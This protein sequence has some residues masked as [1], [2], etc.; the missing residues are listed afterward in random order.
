MCSHRADLWDAACQ[1]E[2]II[3]SGKE[4][5]Q[6]SYIFGPQNILK[7]FIFALC[8]CIFTCMLYVNV[9]HAY[10][11]LMKIRKECPVPGIGDRDDCETSCG[12]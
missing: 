12:C 2:D 7:S 11:V 10:L 8:V 5:Y 6:E 9:L 1:T 3:D 4:C